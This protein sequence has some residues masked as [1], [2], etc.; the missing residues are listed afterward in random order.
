MRRI[1]WTFVTIATL[2]TSAALGQSLGDAARANREKQQEE[3]AS[4]TQPRMFTN[5]DV[6]ADP[7]G[8]PESK[9]QADNAPAASAHPL[10]DRWAD[11]RATVRDQAQQRAAA[12]WKARIDTQEQRIANLQVRIDRLNSLNHSPGGDTQYRG[13]YQYQARQLQL[14]AFLQQQLE[15]QNQRL[16]AMQDAARRA[17]V[18]GP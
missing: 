14:A 9:P 11:Q 5:A 6:P 12:I 17:G 10:Q 3:Q 15:E 16:V 7:P 4:G 2:M 18:Y 1:F 8:T 13:P